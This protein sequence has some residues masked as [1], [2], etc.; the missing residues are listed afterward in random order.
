MGRFGIM[1][2]KAVLEKNSTIED[3]TFSHKYAY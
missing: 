2:C 3:R 1:E